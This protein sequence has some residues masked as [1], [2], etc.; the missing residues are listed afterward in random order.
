MPWVSAAVSALNAVRSCGGCN[1]NDV[2]GAVGAL[3]I[4]LAAVALGS[5]IGWL[6]VRRL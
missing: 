5:V 3:V 1:S 6:V 4:V 2:G